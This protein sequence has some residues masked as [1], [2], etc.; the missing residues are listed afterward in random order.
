MWLALPK[1][2]IFSANVLRHDI[3]KKPHQSSMTS[4]K[5]VIEINSCFMDCFA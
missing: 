4:F 3:M 2:K 1:L 5:Y